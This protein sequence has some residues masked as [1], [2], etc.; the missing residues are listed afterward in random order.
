M[1]QLKGDAKDAS[2]KR[3]KQEQE[4][5]P[6]AKPQQQVRNEEPAPLLK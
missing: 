5:K 4:Q 6:P 1:E 2:R 3:L